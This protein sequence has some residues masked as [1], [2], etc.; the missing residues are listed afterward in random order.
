MKE[1]IVE[2]VCGGPPVGLPD[3]SR[4]C[5]GAPTRNTDD[6]YLC[7]RRLQYCG[8]QKTKSK[9][10]SPFELPSQIASVNDRCI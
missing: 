1:K 7:M 8:S 6:S 5:G 4:M 9:I 10:H 2:G 3:V